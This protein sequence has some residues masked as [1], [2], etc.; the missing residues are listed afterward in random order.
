MA[1]DKWSGDNPWLGL[2]PYTEGT[3]LYGRTQESAILSEIIKDNIATIVYG[4]S[5]IGKSSLLS[6]GISPMLRGE[7]YIPVPL[8]LVHNT[9]VSYVEQIENRVRELVDCKEELPENVPDLGLWDFFHRHT[10][11]KNGVSCQPVIILD[12]FEEIYT[13]TDIE[14]KPEIIALFT[15]LASLLNDI[16]PDAVLAAESSFTEG[17]TTSSSSDDDFSFELSTESSFAYNETVSFRFVICL[18]EDKLYLL[19]RNSANI[20]SI[21]TNRYNLQALSPDSALEVIMCPRP[22]LFSQEEATAIVDKLAD[23]GDEGIR[24]VDPAILSLFLYKYFEKKDEANYDNIFADYYHEATSSIKDKSLA[25][26]EDHLLTLGGY[27]NQIP[28]EDARSGGVSQSEIDSLLKQIIL[29]S[30]KRKG[31]DYIEF[32]HDRLCVEAMTS[33]EERKVR[34]QSRKARKRMMLSFLILAVSVGILSAV[35]LLTFRLQKSEAGRLSAEEAQQLEKEGRLAEQRQKELIKKQS[36]SLA[37]MNSVNMR[38]REELQKKNIELNEQL[39]RIEEQQRLIEE[40]RSLSS[41]D[42]VINN[43][44][45]GRLA[46][47]LP[48]SALM[49]CSCLFVSGSIDGTD[50]KYIQNA[51]RDGKLKNLDLSKTR[52]VEEA[53]GT[54][55][56]ILFTSNKFLKTISLPQNTKYILPKAF[57]GCKNLVTIDIPYTV[58]S[59]GDNAF[60]GCSSLEKVSIPSGV[61]SIDWGA[62]YGCE[63]LSSII[64]PSKV[65]TIRSSTFQYCYNLAS[66]KIPNSV[67]KIEPYAFESCRSLTSVDIPNS[68]VS[69]GNGAFRNCLSLKSITIPNS[70]ISIGNNI[71]LYCPQ[72]KN[73]HSFIK[74][75]NKVNIGS[76][77]DIPS[78]CV[79]H[80]PVGKSEEYKSQSWWKS[81]WKISDDLK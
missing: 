9:E 17:T 56:S 70:T 10:F 44:V 37:L 11:T 58:T 57:E 5:G 55:E 18:R 4:K 46:D 62:F 15:E 36:D 66:I 61:I 48:F 24:T 32:S 68:V 81:T 80:V 65:S 38:Q 28:V 12:Q 34:E 7:Q 75:I 1:N 30:E 69:I 33:R 76:W 6:A 31:I 27:R 72:L 40:L 42:I 41:D 8:R 54:S 63:K 13:L 14:H 49:N 50:I 51:I 45:A 71:L 53:D 60:E 78:D 21:K 39:A 20:P 43:N 67:T 16:K 25:F 22:D 52:V 73:I 47:N 3:P 59:I 77:G 74:N 35:L 19:E 23:M 2:A 26:L 64:I 79:W 29:R